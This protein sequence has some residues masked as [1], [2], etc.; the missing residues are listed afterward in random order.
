MTRIGALNAQFGGNPCET[1]LFEGSNPDKATSDALLA[2]TDLLE[3]LALT[4]WSLSLNN[5]VAIDPSHSVRSIKIIA[6]HFEAFARG[7]ES[8]EQANKE[9]T[10][11]LLAFARQFSADRNS[12]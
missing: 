6:Q 10:D 7:T 8:K 2:A 11:H 9:I 12:P 1:K 5:A 3:A 4:S